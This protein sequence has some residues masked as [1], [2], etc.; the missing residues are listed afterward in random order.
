MFLLDFLAKYEETAT[1]ALTSDPT[2]AV[3][4]MTIN[5]WIL[6][7]RKVNGSAVSFKQNWQEY[8]NGFGSATDNNNYWLGLQKIYR[9][10]KY[11][12]LRLRIE[13][14]FL[15]LF[16]LFVCVNKIFCVPTVWSKKVAHFWYLSFLPY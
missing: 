14:S 16:G 8:R 11:G 13:A 15:P 7:L 1:T 3:P 12:N 6:M 10:Q 4:L 5:G 9:L 2:A